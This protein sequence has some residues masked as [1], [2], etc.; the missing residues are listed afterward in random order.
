MGETVV[1][2]LSILR[3]LLSISHR[4]PSQN[5]YFWAD[6]GSK[7]ISDDNFVFPV[8]YRIT[9]KNEK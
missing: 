5:L 7:F 4:N 2:L 8:V 1:W 9:D 6:L 3:P